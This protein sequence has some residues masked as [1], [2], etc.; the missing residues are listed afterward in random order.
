MS[1]PVFS[2]DGVNGGGSSNAAGIH[3]YNNFNTFNDSIQGD[4][5]IGQPEKAPGDEVIDAIS[6]F[7]TIVD[8]R[9]A[10]TKH[11]IASVKAQGHVGIVDIMDIQQGMF[12]NGLGFSATLDVVKKATRTFDQLLHTQ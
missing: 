7:R 3:D 12:I 11:T 9:Y 1:D 8:E 6:D 2:I 4:L 10:A 5:N